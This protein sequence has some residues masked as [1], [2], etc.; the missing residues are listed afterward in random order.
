MIRF[1]GCE[2]ARE[3]LPLFVDG[4][5]TVAVSDHQGNIVEIV[6]RFSVA[7]R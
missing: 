4:E 2:T 1:F 3:L 5:L 7:A 6:R